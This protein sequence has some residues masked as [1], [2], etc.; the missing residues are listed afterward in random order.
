MPWRIIWSVLAAM[1]IVALVECATGN[2]EAHECKKRGDTWI[3]ADCGPPRQVCSWSK[4]G[5]N[6]AP[7]VCGGVCV[8]P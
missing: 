7:R 5:Q 1:V 4:F 3:A 6:C 8:E 2:N